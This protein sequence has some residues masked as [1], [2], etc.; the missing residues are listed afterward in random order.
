LSKPNDK[1][2]IPFPIVDK[3]FIS[4]PTGGG[5]KSLDETYHYILNLLIVR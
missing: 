5:E 1:N 4:F 3:N 2:F